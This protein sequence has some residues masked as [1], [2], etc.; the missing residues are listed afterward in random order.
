M[1]EGVE[2]RDASSAAGG[3]YTGAATMENSREGP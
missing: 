2:N 1:L 3:L